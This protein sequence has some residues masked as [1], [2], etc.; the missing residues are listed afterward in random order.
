M[1]AKRV[2]HVHLH[3]PFNGKTDFYFGSI[4]AIYSMLPESVLGVKY[5]TLKAKKLTSFENKKCV[6]NVDD[7]IRNER[8]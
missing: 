1:E 8:K 5:N 3:E 4:I 7:L 2:Y 6:I